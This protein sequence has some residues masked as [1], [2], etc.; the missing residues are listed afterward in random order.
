MTLPPAKLAIQL[1]QAIRRMENE[2]RL[3]HGS[4]A[5][6]WEEERK[7]T[8]GD[9]PVTAWIERTAAKLKAEH[10]ALAKFQ[11][12]AGLRNLFPMLGAK[13]LFLK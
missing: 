8:A 2:A 7:S 9:K 11:S 5:R 13:A 12:P 4:I 10:A 1:N 6:A 3:P